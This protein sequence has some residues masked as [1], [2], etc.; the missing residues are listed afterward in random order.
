M[1]PLLTQKIEWGVWLKN[2]GCGREKT[3]NTRERRSMVVV[4]RKKKPTRSL[5]LTLGRH[6]PWLSHALLVTIA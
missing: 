3:A 4:R 6:M 1:N 2:D 5:T